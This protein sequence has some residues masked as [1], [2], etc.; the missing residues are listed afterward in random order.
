MAAGSGDASGSIECGR[1]TCRSSCRPP[2]PLASSCRSPLSRGRESAAPSSA[3]DAVLQ[4]F[5]ACAP[6]LRRYVCSCGLDADAADD[7]VQETFL[8][9]FRHLRGGGADHNLRGWLM[10]VSYRL[11][12]KQRRR[13]ARRQQVEMACEAPPA[14]RVVDPAE[15]PDGLLVATERQRRLQSVLQA[16]PARDRQCLLLR[17]EGMPYRRIGETLGI[18]LGSVAKSIAHGM[19]R[20]SNAAKF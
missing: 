12:L 13:L 4:L 7:V 16:L 9:L 18:S 3:H 14:E 5:D 11:A 10:R 8:A 2:T 1:A 20:L 19:T 17:A 6:A 15:G